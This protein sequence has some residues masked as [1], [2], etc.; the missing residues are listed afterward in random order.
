M[1]SRSEARAPGQASPVPAAG[2]QGRPVTVALAA[3][4]QALE[5]AG[6]LVAAIMA[7][8]AASQGKSYQNSS[9]IAITAIGIGTALVLT[10]V[11][12][13][14]ARVRHWSRTP[15]LMTQFFTG[16]IGIYLVQ[17]QRYEW[18]V[19]A[20]VLAVAGLVLL[21]VRPSLRALAFTA[22]QSS[23]AAK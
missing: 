11:A 1:G 22:K 6:I 17:G 8:V 10:F 5:S 18:G 12:V 15:A 16:V 2:E 9:G 13:G 20:L 14:V 7:G 4:V 21:F 19:P 3:V 23:A